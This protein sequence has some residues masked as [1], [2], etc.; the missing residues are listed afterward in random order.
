MD[1]LDLTD[2]YDGAYTSYIAA[3]RRKTASVAS[4]VLVEHLLDGDGVVRGFADSPEA[5]P[6]VAAYYFRKKLIDYFCDRRDLTPES[7]GGLVATEA[8]RKCALD[9]GLQDRE[10]LGEMFDFFG[11]YSRLAGPVL[12]GGDALAEMERQFG[13]AASMRFWEY[14]MIELPA[15]R[16]CNV[17]AARVL[18]SKLEERSN[19]TV[20]EGGAGIGT[21]LREALRDPRFAHAS[22]N[23][24]R[25]D[26]TDISALLLAIGKEW[27]R[28]HAPTNLFRR[29]K[30]ERLD[31]D[32]L[33]ARTT[34]LAGGA[35]V[36]LIVFEHVLYDVR[37]LHATL[38]A[39]RSMLRDGGVLVFTM[40]FRARPQIFF[41]NELFQSMLHSYNRAKLD[42]PRRRNMG[43]L[44]L[45]EWELSL[46]AA[47]F[48]SWSVYPDPEDHTRWP[49]GGIVARR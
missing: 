37:D 4:A 17:L 5:A 13:A 33:P 14:S 29:I 25:Y 10:I 9:Q 43:Y 6:S 35:T 38:T 7:S 15:K 11:W 2:V 44:T 3:F 31:L 39:C 46:K 12:A 34:A 8:V 16:P 32:R 41:A 1:R 36:D 21:V 48:S 27:L 45:E 30:F 24:A 23:L 40:S 20:F 18:L 28:G 22:Q 19:I 42:P 26:Y 47:G 49:F